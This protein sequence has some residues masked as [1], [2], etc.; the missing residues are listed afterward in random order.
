MCSLLEA[1]PLS[2]PALC[3]PPGTRSHQKPRVCVAKLTWAKQMNPSFRLGYAQARLGK[4]THRDGQA[5]SGGSNDE[6]PQKHAF[7]E[8]RGMRS[9]PGLGAAWGGG[10]RGQFPQ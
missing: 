7:K 1:V 10:S 8:L 3:D 9:A 2:P 5:A 6:G 4:I